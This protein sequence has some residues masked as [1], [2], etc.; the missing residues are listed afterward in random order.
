M[1]TNKTIEAI[2]LG[3]LVVLVQLS[4]FTNNT[5]NAP[6]FILIDLCSNGIGDGDGSY[7]APRMEP[8][9]FDIG[10][11]FGPDGNVD[12]WL[13]QEGA[14]YLGRGNSE[15][16]VPDA[17]RRIYFFQL[18]E[19]A[20]QDVQIHIVDKSEEYYLAINAI[21]INAA[22][23]T[24]VK[25][26][27]TNGYFED[28]LNGWSVVAE[29]TSVA[30]PNSL[31]IRDTD[32]FHVNYSGSFLSTMT[33]PRSADFTETAVL[34]SD[35]FTLPQVSSF[36]YGMVSGGGSEF[37]NLAGALDSDNAS[38]VYIDL[39]TETE[40]PNGQYDDGQD[41]PLVGYWGGVASGGRNDFGS[42]FINTS[43]FEGRRAQ[44]V[45]FDDS[46]EYHIALD[47]FRMNWDWEESII[48]NGGFDQD[49]PSPG[50][51]DPNLQDW[52]SETGDFL[53][54][55]DHPSGGI[56]GWSV[57][58]K[59]GAFGDVFW[60]DVSARA[61]HMSG[62]TYVGTAGGDLTQQGLEIRSDVFTIQS[63]P[64]PSESVFVQFATAQGTNR[65]R[66]GGD[67]AQELAFGRVELIVDVNGNGEF[68]DDGDFKY[69]QTNQGMAYNQ[70]NS[71]RDLWHH[72]EYRWYVRPEH[73]G[74]KAIFEIEDNFGPFK[75]SW[76]WMCVDDLYVW[77]GQEAAL[78]F[79]NSDFEQGSLENW[80]EEIRGGSGFDTWLSGSKKALE[81][82]LVTHST[83]NNRS[84]D[85]DGNFAA[86]TA[87]RETGGGDSGI[88]MLSS[89]PFD[90]PVVAAATAEPTV[91]V[92]ISLSTDGSQV[93]LEWENGTLNSASEANG[94]YVPVAGA[95]SPYTI[96]AEGK[97]QFFQIK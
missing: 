33:D 11:D 56:P 18:D 27:L 79:P 3:L 42:V 73:Q 6:A 40:D 35:V 60:Y 81:D 52:L 94:D 70:S 5:G 7:D 83:M 78:A 13:S 34:V 44:V 41:I 37:V 90:L 95:S 8:D 75:A 1:K 36:I 15:N 96:A 17:W 4:A 76:G 89:M 84:S 31:I 88:G 23:G 53:I 54:H 58:K 67:S 71:G 59:E 61:D 50:S 48:A 43:G 14:A 93:T 65:V 51:N 26:A 62:R 64:N 97:S 63:I 68:G 86:D 22:D 72:P 80:T 87:A 30:D 77:D 12:R 46:F 69:R 9:V 20:G 57:V 82:G 55:S 19:F 28:G 92:T 39:G 24:V 66:Y 49:I 91:P 74:M 85:I 2:V 38:G 10:L 32:A 16:I 21:R 29:D 25:N 47:A 45:G